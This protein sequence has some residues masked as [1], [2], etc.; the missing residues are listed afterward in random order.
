M[1][2]FQSKLLKNARRVLLLVLGLVLFPGCSKNRSLHEFDTYDLQIEMSTFKLT[3]SVIGLCLRE[4]GYS[5]LKKP[6]VALKR[7]KMSDLLTPE[8]LLKNGYSLKIDDPGSEPYSGKFDPL[9]QKLPVSD[10]KYNT[11]LSQCKDRADAEVQRSFSKDFNLFARL[12]DAEKKYRADPRRAE[13]WDGWASCVRR[14]GYEFTGREGAIEYFRQMS[15]SNPV[16]VEGVMRAFVRVDVEC[17][18]NDFQEL[19]SIRERF[20]VGQGK[21]IR[22]SI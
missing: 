3:E 5:Y 17:I 20:E 14:S 16:E 15:I 7:P 10:P 13:I 1:S 12:E 11:A 19:V 22:S 8:H 2:Q 21:T 4:Q 6:F 18:K 9:T